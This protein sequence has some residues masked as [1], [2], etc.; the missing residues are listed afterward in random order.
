MT[1]VVVLASGN[2]SNL[3]TIIDRTRSS[4]L[5]IEIVAVISDQSQAFALQRAKSANIPAL[6]IDPKKFNNRIQYD[7]ELSDKIKQFNCDLIVLAGFMRILSNNFVE[8]YLWRIVN[9]HPSLLPKYKGLDTHARV[10][11]AG[12]KFHGATVHFVTNKLDA[13]PVII[14]KKVPVCAGDTE[15]E[16]KNRVHECEYEIYPT[17]IQ[18]FADGELSVEN[19]QVLRSGK[20]YSVEHSH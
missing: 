15:N 8:N 12:D 11:K 14:Q 10:L 5:S 17:A 20:P 4:K 13:G 3:Q 7:V 16:L 18:W 9:I 6:Y 2:G 19:G 1:R